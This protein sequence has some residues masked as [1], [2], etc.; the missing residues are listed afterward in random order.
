MKN[1]IG[2]LFV[3]F[4][5][6]NIFGQKSVENLTRILS[7]LQRKSD[8]PGFAT[9]IVDEKGVRYEKGFGYADV[10]R[11]IPYTTETIQP[12]GSVSKTLIGIALMR[13]VEN[14]ELSLDA[15]I[16]DYLPFAVRH[17][18][19]P[20]EKITLRQLATH[21]SGIM[22]RE[23]IYAKTYVQTKTNKEPLSGFL[24]D[25]LTAKG[26]YY[27]SRN[28]AESKPG[29]SYNYTNIG[30]TLAAYVIEA[31]TITSFSEYTQ[32]AIFEPL[33]MDSSG[34]FYEE[35]NAARYA[36]LYESKDKPLRPYSSLTYPDGSLRTS[37]SDLAKYI[38]EIIKGASGSGKILSKESFDVLLSKQFSSENMPQKISPKEPN[39]GIFFVHR[40]GGEIGYTGSDYGVSAFM[41]FNPAT[42]TGKIFMTNIDVSE[43][44]K[45]AAQFAEIWKNLEINR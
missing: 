33:S 38:S 24:A 14:G 34:W 2:F 20:D 35:K 10:K 5:S 1:L 41:F 39:Q 27:D 9:A 13:A 4:V 42:K 6:I 17:P 44:P 12:I 31:K 45:L 22:D 40:A 15:D 21:T 36:V 25:Y 3:L 32:K 23:E 16:N 30:A 7:D 43:N 26:K 18:R 8:F 29:A 19:F 28:F 37:V 11:K